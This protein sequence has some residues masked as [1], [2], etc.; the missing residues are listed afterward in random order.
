M[1]TIGERIKYLPAENDPLSAD[2]YCIEGD[3]YCYV[4]DVGNDDRSLQYIN[5]L[6]KERVIIL[7]HYHKD[8]IGNI[9]D[10]HYRDLYV[11]KKT[12]E[13]I[14]KGI[15]VEDAITINDGVRIDVIHCISPHTD[16]SLIIT[17]DNEYTLI[18]DLYFTR[19]PFDKEKAMKMLDSLRNV[20]TKY[21][22]V[23][24]QEDEKVIPKEHLIVEL[25]AYFSH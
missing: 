10:I 14:G 19:A 13:A 15:I 1:N 3:Q 5:E 16:G 11:G 22:V 21:Y 25:T 23:S 6:S 12:H 24:H 17:V 8:H 4:Y 20:D 2:V 9:E 18:A 7:S